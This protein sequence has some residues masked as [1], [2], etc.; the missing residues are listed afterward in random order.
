MLSYWKDLGEMIM[1]LPQQ[2]CK[3]PLDLWYKSSRVFVVE[4][5]IYF[6][7]EAYEITY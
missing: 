4:N 5:K 2:L 6:I 3:D 1:W 7:L